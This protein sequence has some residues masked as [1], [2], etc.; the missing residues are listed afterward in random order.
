M[1]EGE[2]SGRAGQER[3]PALPN[4]AVRFAQTF[5]S[6][7]TLFERLRRRPAWL[8]ALLLVVAIHVAATVLVPEEMFHRLVSRELPPATDPESVRGAVRTL[9]Y[10]DI[11]GSLLRPPVT[12]LV[13][14]A[15]VILVY[16]VIL[17]GGAAYRQA[18]AAATHALFIAAA[19]GVL[20]L[21]LMSARGDMETALALHLL[22]PG[23]EEG[24]GYRLL[25]GLNLFGLWTAVVLGIAVG[26]I[27]PRRSGAAAAA[28]LVGLYAAFKAALA[29]IPGV[30]G[31]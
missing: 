19:G 31:M 22:A 2:G 3:E 15:V 10:W 27:Y 9:R 14:A 23:L 4:L 29:F 7:G 11:A 21:A 20:A 5:V 30:G 26:R 17:G 28:L 6:P 24:Y 1:E 8:G 16:N 13:L 18:F 12:A 25:H